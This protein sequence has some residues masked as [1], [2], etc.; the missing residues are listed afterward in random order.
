LRVGNAA[1]HP[2]RRRVP[3]PQRGAAAPRATTGELERLLGALRAVLA[4]AGY[5]GR[6]RSVAVLAE[7]EAYLKRGRPTSREVTLLLGAL[8]ALARAL[9]GPRGDDPV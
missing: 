1:A 6:G 3:D 9:P 2:D 8:G 7:I 4:A 5:P